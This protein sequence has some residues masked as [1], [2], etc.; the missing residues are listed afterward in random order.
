LGSGRYFTPEECTNGTPLILVGKKIASKLKINVDDSI[1]FHGEKYRVI[2]IMGTDNMFSDWDDLISIPLKSLPKDYLKV[3]KGKVV[4]NT[5]MLNNLKLQMIFR[6]KQSK[7]EK[8]KNEILSNLNYNNLKI[9]ETD[10]SPWVS[11]LDTEAPKTILILIPIIVA[12]LFNVV[13]ISF[14]WIMDRKKE[15]TIKKAIGATNKSIISSVRNELLTIGLIA[16]ILSFIVQVLLESTF[17]SSL[18]KIGMSLEFSWITFTICILLTLGIS[19]VTTMLPAEKILSMK[20]A[21]ALRY[22]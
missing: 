7:Y 5:G 13:N 4:E 21:E 15:I 16:T 17:E 14:F 12:A 9:E 1:E 22:E 10:A 3:L 11:S 20:P 6:V 2:G 18:Y 8:V 19:Y